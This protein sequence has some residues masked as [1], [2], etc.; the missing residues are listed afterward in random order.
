MY[1]AIFEKHF[2]GC[3]TSLLTSL[4]LLGEFIPYK[5]KKTPRSTFPGSILICTTS[6]YL[7]PLIFSAYLIFQT[8]SFFSLINLEPSL[9]GLHI[10]GTSVLQDIL[11]HKLVVITD[12]LP[13]SYTLQKLYFIS[14]SFTGAHFL[15]LSMTS[16]T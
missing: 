8:A 5:L 11:S 1:G 7:Q 10:L 14:A 12:S 16:L 2:S 4:I 3:L 6:S 9:T 15:L 13:L